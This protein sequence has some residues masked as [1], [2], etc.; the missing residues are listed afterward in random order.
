MRP[1]HR[2]GQPPTDPGAA[3]N[4]SSGHP[5]TGRYAVGIGTHRRSTSDVAIAD[6]PSWAR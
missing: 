1:V 3:P 4:S 6:S 2:Q 5:V